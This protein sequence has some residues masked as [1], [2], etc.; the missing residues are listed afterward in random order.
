MKT[1]LGEQIDDLL[2]NPVITPTYSE[3]HNIKYWTMSPE[4][5]ATN[6]NFS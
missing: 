6:L 1:N 3:R 4:Y 5:E 2:W